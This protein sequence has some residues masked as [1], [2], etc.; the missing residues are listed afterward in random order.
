MLTWEDETGL[1]GDASA[2][3]LFSSL[4]LRTEEFAEKFAQQNDAQ[5]RS[6]GRGLKLGGIALMG[7]GVALIVAANTWGRKEECTERITSSSF[8]MECFTETN[9]GLAWAG[10]AAAGLGAGL[11]VVGIRKNVQVGVSPTSLRL[12]VKF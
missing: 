3:Y 1:M 12:S 8:S 10:L 6:G 4:G 9:K 7:T 11:T 2:Y 5:A